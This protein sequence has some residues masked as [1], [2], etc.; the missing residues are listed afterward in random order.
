[1]SSEEKILFKR[2][3]QSETEDRW[4]RLKWIK[5]KEREYDIEKLVVW[6]HIRLLYNNATLAYVYELYLAAILSICSSLEAFISSKI[7]PEKVKRPKYLSHYIRDALEEGLVSDSVYKQL[8]KFN[9]N[10]RNHVVHPKG[11]TSLGNLGFK[12]V[13]FSGI[14]STWESPDRKPMSPLTM[15]EAAEKGVLLFM[16]TVK[17]WMDLK[18]YKNES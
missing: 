17:H 15:K 4:K 7:S 9:D 5:E 1:M 18:N 3:Y 16:E 12:L 8:K 14:K 11:P 6:D 10:I 13:T 2:F